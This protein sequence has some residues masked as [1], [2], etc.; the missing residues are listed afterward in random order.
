[1]IRDIDEK[2]RSDMI[3]GFLFFAL[4]AQ[5]VEQLPFKQTVPGSSP[6][7]RTKQLWLTFFFGFV[8]MPIGM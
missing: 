7:G 2:K 8:T 6:G 1:M 5:L 3:N 4:I